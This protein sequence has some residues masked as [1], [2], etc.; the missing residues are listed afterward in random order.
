[1]TDALLKGITAASIA[2]HQ[3]REERAAHVA[4][5]V[6]DRRG[7]AWV[8]IFE[9]DENEEGVLLGESGSGPNGEHLSIP[10]LGP[11]TG[12]LMGTLDVEGRNELD[13]DDE[14]FLEDCSAALLALFE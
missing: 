4:Q 5:I 14:V 9:I 11:D 6:R 13:H 3:S 12:A 8:G 1:M 10:I 7:Y 2:E